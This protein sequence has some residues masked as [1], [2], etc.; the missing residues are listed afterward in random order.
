L[1]W[2]AGSVA[3]TSLPYLADLQ[4]WNGRSSIGCNRTTLFEHFYLQLRK[5]Y[6]P[7][8][9]SPIYV[10]VIP[11]LL[12]VKNHVL[13]TKVAPFHADCKS[14]A[15]AAFDYSVTT[16]LA[17]NNNNGAIP[18]W[19]A[20]AT[21]KVGMQVAA[22]YMLSVPNATIYLPAPGCTNC[23][24]VGVFKES[25][26]YGYLTSSFG[27][28]ERMVGQ[29]RNKLIELEVVLPSGQNGDINSPNNKNFVSQWSTGKYVPLRNDDFRYVEKDT[30][31]PE[32]Y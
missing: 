12:M 5:L 20:H 19:S 17:L 3:N 11:D 28:S 31:M 15:A 16:L 1:G 6:S 30:L 25:T 21:S 27:A 24:N 4:K 13:C 26:K 14:F 8:K 9:G 32:N 10:E 22:H 29:V 18:A 23:I 2:I 7:V